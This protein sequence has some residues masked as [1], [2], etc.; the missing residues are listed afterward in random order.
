MKK[1]VLMQLLFCLLSVASFSQVPEGAFKVVASQYGANPEI[2]GTGKQTVLKIFKDGY[3]IAAFFGDPARPFYGSGGGS[4]TVKN[5]KYVEKL[6]FYSWDSTAVGDVY[7]FDYTL[8]KDRYTQEGYMDS[9]KY[10]NYLI[11]E[12]FE[13][14]NVREPLKNSQLEGVWFMRSG[15]WGKD[16]LGEGIYKDVKV[17]KIFSYPRFAFAYYND[18]TKSFVGA[19][20]G[21]YQFDGTTLTENIEYWS[22]GSPKFPLSVFK[23]K[24][25]NNRYVQEGWENGLT[26]EWEKAK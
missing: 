1:S 22:W 20:G 23:V 17:I 13:K 7:T 16:K 15:E 8:N 10:K 21:T 12:K 5:G 4:F 18:K 2:I 26:E 9:E 24:I 25:N 14:L 3:W 19:G 6:D 11:K